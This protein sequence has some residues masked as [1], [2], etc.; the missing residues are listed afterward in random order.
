ML[1]LQPALLIYQYI[2]DMY[3]Y[4]MVKSLLQTAYNH[5]VFQFRKVIIDYNFDMFIEIHI[6]PPEI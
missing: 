5:D 6:I 1:A 4:G 2:H 3:L